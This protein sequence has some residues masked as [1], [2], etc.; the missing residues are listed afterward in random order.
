MFEFAIVLLI[1]QMPEWKFVAKQKAIREKKA[2]KFR[3]HKITNVKK[4]SENLDLK[5]TE[6]EQEIE[7]MRSRFPSTH[8]I[9]IAALFAFSILYLLFNGVYWFYV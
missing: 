4:N 9:D 2:R 3:N 5:M 7:M 1:K 6:N 8:K